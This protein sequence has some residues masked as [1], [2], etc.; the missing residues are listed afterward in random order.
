MYAIA[1]VRFNKGPQAI[2]SL[3]NVRPSPGRTTLAPYQQRLQAERRPPMPR[4]PQQPVLLF[5][6]PW[7]LSAAHERAAV[8]SRAPACECSR[9]SYLLGCGPYPMCFWH[10]S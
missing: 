1:E 4:L 3:A 6:L 5:G 9:E 7:V 2:N 10:I 8:C